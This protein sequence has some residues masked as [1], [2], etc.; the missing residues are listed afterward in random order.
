MLVLLLAFSLN[1]LGQEGESEQEEPDTIA[2]YTDYHEAL[3]KAA[4]ED[5]YMLIEFYT[6]W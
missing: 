4:A 2:W 5:R 1:L 6:D 3:Q